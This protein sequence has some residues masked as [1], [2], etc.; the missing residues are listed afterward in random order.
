MFTS[1]ELTPHMPDR[2]NQPGYNTIWKWLGFIWL[3]ITK[4][5]GLIAKR[6]AVIQPRAG[7]VRTRTPQPQRLKPCTRLIRFCSSSENFE[8]MGDI[9]RSVWLGEPFR[10]TVFYFD[11]RVRE[12]WLNG[13]YRYCFGGGLTLGLSTKPDLIDAAVSAHPGPL[14]I[15]YV[16]RCTVPLALIC[17][18]GTSSLLLFRAEVY[19]SWVKSMAYL[20]L[21]AED[22]MMT[23]AQRNECEAI[24]KRKTDIPSEVLLHK[25]ELCSS[26]LHSFPFLSG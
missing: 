2:P 18:E 24:L 4:L 21:R 5:P 12:S 17:A 10:L 19:P 11:S 25:G 3:I 26:V 20:W 23:E 16:N 8:R 6:P 1:E 7:E 22:D 15:G 13:Q 14:N 9:A